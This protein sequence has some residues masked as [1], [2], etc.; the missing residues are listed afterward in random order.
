MESKRA[1]SL[2]PRSPANGTTHPRHPR[3]VMRRRNIGPG[4]HEH[5]VARVRDDEG[6]ALLQPDTCVIPGASLRLWCADPIL[7]SPARAAPSYPRSRLPFDNLAREMRCAP[8]TQARHGDTELEGRCYR[9]ALGERAG[10]RRS[11]FDGGASAGEWLPG[12][13]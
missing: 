11:V 12:R 6:P 7:S 10:A 13:R 3:P 9:V 2:L 1:P 4:Q 8:L 5:L